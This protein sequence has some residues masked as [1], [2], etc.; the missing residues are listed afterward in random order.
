MKKI[1]RVMSI[2]SNAINII[3]IICV[4]GTMLAVTA[5]VIMRFVFSNP[6][7]GITELV[8]C[9]FVTM[10]MSFGVVVLENANTMV[11]VFTEKMHP[12]VKR[13]IELI[14]DVVAIA[15]SIVVGWR[16]I[17]KAMSSASS[18]IMYV[19]LG[20]KEWPIMVLFAIGFFV[21]AIATIVF[22]INEW[23]ANTELCRQYKLN[24]G[25]KK[26]AESEEA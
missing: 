17:V 12:Q 26:T 10:A 8:Q 1:N 23:I 19:M 20:I 2:F 21:A 6:I 16:T 13:I 3:A 22:T 9:F 14:T 4:V 7:P 24:G 5:D 15:F 25:K 11:D 18:N